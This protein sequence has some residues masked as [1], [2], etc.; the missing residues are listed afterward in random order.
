[1]DYQR[2]DKGEIVFEEL[3]KEQILKAIKK[4]DA[5][6]RL[7][8]NR[9]FKMFRE[10]FKEFENIAMKNL[11]DINSD[12]TNEINKWQQLAKID[13]TIDK[14]MTSIKQE[15]KLAHEEAKEREKA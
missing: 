11:V 1:L 10:V 5:M 3:N 6:D 13:R 4:G 9:D 14:I 2:D 15:G 7:E 12:D 8:R